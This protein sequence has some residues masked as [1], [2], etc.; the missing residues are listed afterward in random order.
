ME[1]T[2]FEIT[3]KAARINTGIS[4][5]R[6]VAV[7]GISKKK[8]DKWEHNSGKIQLDAAAKLAFLYGLP[9]KNLWFGKAKDYHKRISEGATVTRE[10]LA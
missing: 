5:K 2:T 9:L 8:L 10:V 3:L 4:K 6:A 1:R 7:T